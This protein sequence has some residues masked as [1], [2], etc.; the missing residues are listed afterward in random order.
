MAEC[1]TVDPKMVVRPHPCQLAVIEKRI[2][3]TT[4]KI[5]QTQELEIYKQ[6]EKGGKYYYRVENFI[7]GKVVFLSREDFLKEY[8]A[9]DNNENI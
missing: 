1:R 4:R 8:P 6:K 3:M 9:L 7:S 2:N 5:I